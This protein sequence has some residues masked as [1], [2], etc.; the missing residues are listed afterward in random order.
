M[1]ARVN[2]KDKPREEGRR[3]N[4]VEESGEAMDSQ[5]DFVKVLSITKDNRSGDLCG[6]CIGPID[7]EVDGSA[8]SRSKSQHFNAVS[9]T[10]VTYLRWALAAAAAA[11][12]VVVVVVLLRRWAF[13]R[14]PPGG[15]QLRSLLLGIT[16]TWTLENASAVSHEVAEF[17]SA[18]RGEMK[19]RQRREEKLGGGRG[20]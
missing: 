20:G 17:C 3:L 8:R 16:A 7:Q 2:A 14:S 9:R 1:G 12:V 15:G 18:G 4:K 11:V 19:G 13:F 5:R 6:M 10:E